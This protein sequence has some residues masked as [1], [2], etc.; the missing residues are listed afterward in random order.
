MKRIVPFVLFGTLTMME[1]P[2]FSA[3][4][5][6][7]NQVMQAVY[8]RDEA[9][10]KY[11]VSIGLNINAVD[12]QGKTPLCRVIE[13]QDY[14]GYELLL[15]QGA[16][17]RVP[18]VRD[19]NPEILD[20]FVAEQPPLGT[21]YKGATL[22][23]SQNRILSAGKEVSSTVASLPIIPHIGE[24]LLGGVAVGAASPSIFS[25]KNLALIPSSS[26]TFL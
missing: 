11:L 23:S 6:A 19:M 7:H 22:T 26:R 12:M 17:T 9:G 25:S 14:E 8:A 3:P 16:T 21:Y 18:C 4:I 10:L 1:L 24:I 20:R 2:V 13:N 5:G 15:S